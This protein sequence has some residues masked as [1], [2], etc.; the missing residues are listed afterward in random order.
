MK[1]TE[2]QLNAMAPWEENMR[3]AVEAQWARNPGTQGLRVIWENFTKATGDKRRFNDNCN[4]CIFSLLV[5]CGK[6]YFQ[7]KAELEARKAATKAVEV[8][9]T[10]KEVVK[11]AK[12][13][14]AKKSKN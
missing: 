7:D 9:Q 11:K 3:I 2:E 6:I 12:V 14:T 5:D 10:P 8:S 4:H 13:K 1:F